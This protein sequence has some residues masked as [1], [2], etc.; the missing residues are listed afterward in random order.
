M[1]T[2]WHTLTVEEGLSRLDSQP[3]GLTAPEAQERLARFGPNALKEQKRQS[4]I[5][6]FLEQFKSFLIIILLFAVVASAILGDTLEA[7]LILVIVVFAAGLGF[8]Q[9]YRA[10]RAIEALARM[11][12]PSATVIR[13]GKEQEIDAQKLVPGDVLVLL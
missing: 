8:A 11:A 10:E 12:A 9:E 13:D 3:Q 5:I 7:A 6:L 2:A 4:P 1:E